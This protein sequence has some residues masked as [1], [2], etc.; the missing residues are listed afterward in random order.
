MLFKEMDF[1]ILNNWREWSE[2]SKFWHPN[3]Y[4]DKA[5]KTNRRTSLDRFIITLTLARFMTFCK[6]PPF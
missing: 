4:Y 3:P 6:V 5:I 2:T 1:R